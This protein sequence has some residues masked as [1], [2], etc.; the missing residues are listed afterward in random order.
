M[1]VYAVGNA[2]NASCAVENLHK[3]EKI[4]FNGYKM[5]LLDG[6][7]HA[8]TMTHFARAIGRDIAQYTRFTVHP[9]E[10]LPRNHGLKSLKSLDESLTRLEAENILKPDDFVAI[11]ITAPVELNQLAYSY[12]RWQ[13]VG[14]KFTPANIKSKKDD[15]MA[16]LSHNGRQIDDN[17]QGFGYIPNIIQTINRLV[18]KGV[19]VFIPSDHPLEA[20][21]KWEAENLGIKHLL[22]KYIS[23]GVDE[24]GQINQI[25]RNLK[26]KNAY[27]FNL[28]T[29][30]D[31]HVVNLQNYKE[32]GD[33]IFSAFDSC[34]TDRARGVYNF[35]PVRNSDGRVLGYSFTDRKTIDY[36]YA[37]YPDNQGIENILKFVGR[38]QDDFS[39]EG[40]IINIMRQLLQWEEPVDKMPD[41]PYPLGCYPK[42]RFDADKTLIS[43]GM[44]FN[45]EENLFFDVN[46]EGEFIFRNC[47]CEGSGRPSVVS[48][49]G[50]CFAT[51]NLMTKNVRA[52]LKDLFDVKIPNLM[53]LA[54]ESKDSGCLPAAENILKRALELA[55]PEVRNP[56]FRTQREYDIYT[57]LYELYGEQGRIDDAEKLLLDAFPDRGRDIRRAIDYK[58]ENLKKGIIR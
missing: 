14:E 2:P 24:G 7:L 37:D 19:E 9:I 21:I 16:F 43:R 50:S 42:K 46:K 13:G 32:N 34:V 6:G 10:L 26:A 29:L 3:R 44:Y 5:H 39:Y 56:G 4:N 31:A 41:V 35:C 36:D 51:I 27:K 23:T 57:K 48:M 52:Q 11:P 58:I 8:D 47:D 18:Q 30:S 17:D 33:Y 40:N 38:K 12:S 25:I 1:R 20:A 49:W 45:R 22:Y 53:R 15:I 55:R 54:Q 28:L